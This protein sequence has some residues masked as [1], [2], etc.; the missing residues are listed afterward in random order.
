MSAL[1]PQGRATIAD[2]AGRY[3]L[4]QDAVEHMARAVANG[5]G[6]MAQFNV[7]E[8]GGNGQWMA[9]GMTMVG[10]MF[11]T[12]LQN[13]VQNLC[14]ELSNA[15]ANA[16]FFEQDQSFGGSAW[17]P[18]WLGQPASSGGQNSAR[19]AYFPQARRLAFDFGDGRPVVLMDTGDHQIGGFSQQQSGPG[20]PYMG[21]SVS[22]QF[23][24]YSLMSFP[25][26]PESAQFPPVEENAAPSQPEPAP[27][28]PAPSPAVAPSDTADDILSTIEKLA[29]LRDAG[30]IT[31]QEFDTKK[32]ELLARL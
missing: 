9:G 31:A 12:G 21:V 19:Y 29:R 17:W 25:L 3:G 14:G 28:T 10:D 2:I 15:M 27:Y 30:A 8:L 5:G 4:S 22:S 32:S 11:N 20:D 18:E 1:T 24:Q 16:S 6:T 23:G 7:P 13:T 26:A